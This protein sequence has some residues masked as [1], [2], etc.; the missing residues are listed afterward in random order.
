MYSTNVY[1]EGSSSSSI[2][3]NEGYVELRGFCYILISIVPIFLDYVSGYWGDIS[4]QGGNSI[5]LRARVHDV[6]VS[7][8][9]IGLKVPAEKKQ[10]C[11]SYTGIFVLH[12][13]SSDCFRV[14]SSHC[15]YSQL[16]YSHKYSLLYVL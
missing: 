1:S 15:S 13:I 16:T 7:K 5:L 9:M 6:N 14:I 2:Q 12:I 8:L 4:T 10:T 11:L 3:L